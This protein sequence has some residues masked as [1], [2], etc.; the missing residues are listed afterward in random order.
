MLERVS[1]LAQ[2]RAVPG[3]SQRS[4]ASLQQYHAWPERYPEMA[5]MLAGQCG[6]PEAPAPGKAVSGA[7]G[8]LLRIHPQRLWLFSEQPHDHPAL[9]PQIGVSLDLSHARTIIHVAEGIAVPLLTRFIAI[10][11][12]P[13]R[14][15]IDDVAVTPLHRVSVVL[16][17]RR[18]GIDILAPR[19]FA[20]SVW[21]VLSEAGERLG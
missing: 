18:E 14:F 2:S 5:R 1:P 4:C 13:H 7:G 11:L 10:D 16:W 21:D 17:R 20:R 12:R 8:A 19:S 9:D 6:T 15:A 3:L